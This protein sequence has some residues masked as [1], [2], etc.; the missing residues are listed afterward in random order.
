MGPGMEDPVTW[1]NETQVPDRG[2]HRKVP[3]A[4]AFWE[5]RAAAGRISKFGHARKRRNRV[6]WWFRSGEDPEIQTAP[7][8]KTPSQFPATR[9]GHYPGEKGEKGV[10]K[11]VSGTFFALPRSPA[12]PDCCFQAQPFDDPGSPP[13]LAIRGKDSPVNGTSAPVRLLRRASK[14]PLARHLTDCLGETPGPGGGGVSARVPELR[15]RHPA[16]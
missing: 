11:K 2:R 5:C 15:R 16:H 9:A 3:P 6:V 7:G 4:A 14:N 13:L 10:M 8:P 1:K 12:G